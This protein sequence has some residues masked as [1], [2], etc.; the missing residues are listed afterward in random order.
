M[1][2][3][4]V[5]IGGSNPYLQTLPSGVCNHILYRPSHIGHHDKDREIN[6]EPIFLLPLINLIFQPFEKFLSEG[7]YQ[8]SDSE[9]VK[10]R[11]HDWC[12]WSEAMPGIF[13]IIDRSKTN[14]SPATEN[15]PMAFYETGCYPDIEGN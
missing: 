8:I 1:K 7:R 12:Q 10:L 13:R 11:I 14:H 6:L 2:L 4:T 15:T 5:G 9:I 3:E